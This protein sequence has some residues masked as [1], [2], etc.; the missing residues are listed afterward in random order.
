MDKRKKIKEE[1]RSDKKGN[2]EKGSKDK[3]E[4]EKNESKEKTNSIQ[5]IYYMLP[6]HIYNYMY[7]YII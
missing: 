5:L 4:R 3:K 6:S 7:Q 1:N 2:N